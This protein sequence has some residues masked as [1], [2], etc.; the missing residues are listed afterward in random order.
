[1]SRFS[2]VLLPVA[3]VQQH[4]EGECLAACA[5]MILAYLGVKQAYRQL[6]TLLDVM[7]GVGAPSFN[8]LRLQRIGIRVH[9]SSGTLAVLHRCL[10]L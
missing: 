2:R 7:P 9:Y 3:H 8:I 10:L 1:M 6:V 5:A 4:H